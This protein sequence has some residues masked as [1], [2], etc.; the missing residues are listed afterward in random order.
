MKDS[1]WLD[2]YNVVVRER[3]QLREQLEQRTAALRHYQQCWHTPDL[4]SVCDSVRLALA[5]LD[6]KEKP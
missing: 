6:A 3:D 5:D 2:R 4:C 1:V